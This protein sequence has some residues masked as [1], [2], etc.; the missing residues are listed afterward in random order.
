MAKLGQNIAETDLY[1]ARESL[2]DHGGNGEVTSYED[3]GPL[4]SI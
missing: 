1:L 4:H 3:N 2:L